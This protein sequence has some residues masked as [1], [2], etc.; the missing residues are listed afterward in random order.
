MSS[1][2]VVALLV[3]LIPAATSCATMSNRPEA[4][5]PVTLKVT[6]T[7]S[8][9]VDVYVLADGFSTRMGTVSTAQTG[10]FVVPDRAW[11]SASGLR[12]I[13]DPIGSRAGF[14]SERINGIEP[15]STINFQVAPDL[16]LT[17]YNVRLAASGQPSTGG[18]VPR[19]R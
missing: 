5:G 3:G 7:N 12:V 19:P 1:R 18:G 11:Q 17:W 4:T 15:G 10:D 8:M 13:I 9:D 6:D 16:S 14:I 2:M